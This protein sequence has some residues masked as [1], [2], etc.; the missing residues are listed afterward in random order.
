MQYAFSSAY[1]IN[2]NTNAAVPSN[3]NVIS[4]E[5]GESDMEDPINQWYCPETNESQSRNTT[6][7]T[8]TKVTWSN[9]TKP[10]VTDL[11]Q[12]LLYFQLG[13]DLLYFNRDEKNVPVVYKGV[14][15][16][17]LLPKRLFIDGVKLNVYDSNLQLLY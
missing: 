13:M 4:N 8:S 11:S 10:L 6:L 16:N 1:S 14:R 15:S 3:P 12:K 2:P 17:G 7:D 9:N 5:E